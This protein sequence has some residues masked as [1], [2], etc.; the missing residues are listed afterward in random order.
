MLYIF[1]L[2]GTLVESYGVRPLEGAPARLAQ[3]HAEGHLLAVATNQAGPAWGIA[4]R[5]A[6]YPTPESLGERF[7]EIAEVLPALAT[8]PWFVAVGD[9]RLSLGA[10]DYTALI[11]TFQDAAG[12]LDIR[13]SADPAWCKPEPGMLL[14]ACA[15]Y[16]Q[17]PSAA[18]YIGD[19]ETDAAAAAAAGMSFLP[20]AEYL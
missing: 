7:Q 17:H 9:Q 2:D 16:Q 19:S 4:T 10:S 5:D 1:D 15:A 20:I 3:L 14:A 8:A 6:K 13:L 12:S 11:Q 18:F